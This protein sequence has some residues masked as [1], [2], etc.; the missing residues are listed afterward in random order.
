[1]K[2]YGLSLR[3]KFRTDARLLHEDSDIKANISS[4]LFMGNFLHMFDPATAKALVKEQALRMLHRGG[5]V[6]ASVDGVAAQDGSADAYLQAV[7]EHKK[8][9]SAMSVRTQGGFSEGE[10]EI[11]TDMKETLFT[12]TE[13]DE[14]GKM[15]SECRRKDITK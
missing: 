7:R 15:L 2:E 8:F 10:G 14:E 1:M 13:I 9:P 3:M 5:N 4:V 12:H 11:R 6:F